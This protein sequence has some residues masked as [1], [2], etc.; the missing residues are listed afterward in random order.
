MLA[1][2]MRS[3]PP[4][5]GQEILKSGRRNRTVELRHEP[6]RDLSGHGWAG[7]RSGIGAGW[8]QPICCNM[9]SYYR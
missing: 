9:Q 2:T 6:L 5:S 1:L 7:R 4:S 3:A 8:F